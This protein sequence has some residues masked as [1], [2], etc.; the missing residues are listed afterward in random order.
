MMLDPSIS[1][2]T[3]GALLQLWERSFPFQNSPKNLDPSYRWFH[4]GKPHLTAE[5]HLADLHVCGNLVTVN[6][7]AQLFKASLA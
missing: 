7:R 1:S 2:F 5:L 3:T 4:K 6:S